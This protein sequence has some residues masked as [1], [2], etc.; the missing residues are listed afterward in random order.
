MTCD[1]WHVTCDIWHVTH[2]T[3]HVT[4]GRG[5]TF[6]KSFSSLALTVFQVFWRLGGKGSLDEW[7][8]YVSVCKTTLATPDLIIMLSLSFLKLL[9]CGSTV[10]M[11][12]V[13][14][15]KMEAFSAWADLSFLFLDYKYMSTIPV[16]QPRNEFSLDLKKESNTIRLIHLRI[17]Q[18]LRTHA[19]PDS[20]KWFSLLYLIVSRKLIYCPLIIY[21]IVNLH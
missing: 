5:W 8:K 17:L 2:D 21:L 19:L 1:T 13:H 7:I 14:I 18:T 15:Q 10:N 11:L 3:W 20:F 9:V 12:N 6:S 4:H 16:Y